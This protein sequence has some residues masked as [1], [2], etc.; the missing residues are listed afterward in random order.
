MR[1]GA[2]RRKSGTLYH[3]TLALSMTDRSTVEAFAGWGGANGVGESRRKPANHRTTYRCT[4]YGLKAIKAIRRMLPHTITKRSQAILILEWFAV[5]RHLS[6]AEHE[7]YMGEVAKL[8]RVGEY[9]TVNGSTAPN[10]QV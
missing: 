1:I 6:A 5:R 10:V 9:G 2:T 8:K 4:L 3:V 7:Y